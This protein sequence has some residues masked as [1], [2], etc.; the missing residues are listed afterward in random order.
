MIAKRLELPRGTGSL[1]GMLGAFGRRSAN[2]YS[3]YSPIET[4]YNPVR[5]STELSM[6]KAEAEV[7]SQIVNRRPKAIKRLKKA[8]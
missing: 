8:Q 6:P 4:I 1:A 7:I 2:R 3:G 5:D